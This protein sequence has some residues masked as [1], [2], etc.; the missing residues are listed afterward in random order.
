MKGG[1]DFFVL[2]YQSTSVVNNVK[3]ARTGEARRSLVEKDLPPRLYSGAS[4]G[5]RD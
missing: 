4:R 3:N 5:T 2:R 1:R